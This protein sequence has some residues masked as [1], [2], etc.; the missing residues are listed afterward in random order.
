MSKV[1]TYGEIGQKLSEVLGIKYLVDAKIHFPLD[2]LVTADVT[3]YVDE[4][5]AKAIVELCSDGKWRSPP[6]TQEV[7]DTTTL[8]TT[9]DYRTSKPG[10]TGDI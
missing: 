8:N 7:A 9:G 5:Q 10:F 4:I 6:F 3:F 2:G 1:F